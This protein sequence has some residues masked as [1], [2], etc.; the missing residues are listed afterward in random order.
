MAEVTDNANSVT[1]EKK[2]TYKIDR[3]PKSMPKAGHHCRQIV[4]WI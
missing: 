4:S 2:M 1:D 3:A